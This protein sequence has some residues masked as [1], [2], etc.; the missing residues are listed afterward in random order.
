MHACKM[1]VYYVREIVFAIML[2]TCVIY[3]I[4]CCRQFRHFANCFNNTQ[5]KK[6]TNFET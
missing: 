2:K 4:F 3:E 5:G 1:E 6:T